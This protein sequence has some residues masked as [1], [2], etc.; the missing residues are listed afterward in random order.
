[1]KED[2]F[3]TEDHKMGLT[4]IIGLNLFLIRTQS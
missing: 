1:M 4:I 3:Q 2:L